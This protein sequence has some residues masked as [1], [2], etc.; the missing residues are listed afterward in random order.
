MLYNIAMASKNTTLR[1][2]LEDKTKILAFIKKHD[3]MT[4]ALAEEF[5]YQ[6]VPVLR[7]QPQGILA[8]LDLVKITPNAKTQTDTPAS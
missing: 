3:E 1:K 4:R 6:L 5:G 2:E 8:V 7:V